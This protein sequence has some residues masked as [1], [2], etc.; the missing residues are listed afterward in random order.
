VPLLLA[1]PTLPNMAP[2]RVLGASLFRS[3]HLG[4]GAVRVQVAQHGG[5]RRVGG[6]GGLEHAQHHHGEE[7]LW[8]DRGCLPPLGQGA[9]SSLSEPLRTR[10]DVS[11]KA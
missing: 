2:P 9:G 8:R 5:A 1:L 11:T 6:R 3:P 10:V 7:H 4:V